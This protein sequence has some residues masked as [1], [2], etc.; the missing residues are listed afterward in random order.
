MTRGQRRYHLL[1]W[2]ICLPLIG[3]LFYLYSMSG[4]AEIENE[5][6]IEPVLLQ[7]GDGS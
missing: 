3:L 7:S 1:F 5:R 6:P 2:L 4:G